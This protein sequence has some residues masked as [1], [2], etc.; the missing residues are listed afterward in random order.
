MSADR[1]KYWYKDIRE[2]STLKELLYGS[3]KLYPDNPAFW[4]KKKKGM[5]YEAIS[6]T[7][8]KHDVEALGTK[9]YGAFGWKNRRYGRWRV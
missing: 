1:E 3:Q 9:R 4:V 2:I 6:Y 7:L 5:E 8:L